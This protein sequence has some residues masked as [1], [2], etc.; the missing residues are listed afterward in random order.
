LSISPVSSSKTYTITD[1]FIPTLLESAPFIATDASCP[2]K[3]THK[4]SGKSPTSSA[5]N[6]LFK[7]FDVADYKKKAYVAY[8][9]NDLTL[10]NEYTI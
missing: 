6:V 5:I 4:V 7:I 3:Y 8:P 1:T 9:T 10:A 2:L